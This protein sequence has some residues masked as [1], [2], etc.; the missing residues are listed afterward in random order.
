[1]YLNVVLD[2]CIK[3]VIVDVVVLA[4]AVNNLVNVLFN[5]YAPST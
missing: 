5:G 4:V 2:V 3:V 1:M